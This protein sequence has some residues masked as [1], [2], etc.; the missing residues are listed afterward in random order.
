VLL[1]VD[2]ID[3]FTNKR[4]VFKSE[5]ADQQQEQQPAEAEVAPTNSS[6]HQPQRRWAVANV[7]P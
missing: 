3:L 7:N 4:A 6:T 2:H 1:Q 5:E